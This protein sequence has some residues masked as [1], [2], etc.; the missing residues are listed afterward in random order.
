MADP[1]LTLGQIAV[2]LNF[3][4]P[5]HS[6]VPFAAGPAWCRVSTGAIC[7]RSRAELQIEPVGV[8]RPASGKF[9]I[10]APA[11]LD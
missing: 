8:I 2:L 4:M 9:G 11:G 10:P 5:V 3:P 6:I 7:R 1:L